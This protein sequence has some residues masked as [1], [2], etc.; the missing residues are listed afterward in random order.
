MWSDVAREKGSHSSNKICPRLVGDTSNPEQIQV[1]LVSGMLS[2]QCLRWLEYLFAPSDIYLYHPHKLV[3]LYFSFNS[4]PKQGAP[5]LLFFFFC[6][7]LTYG[8]V[9]RCGLIAGA[10]LVTYYWVAAYLVKKARQKHAGS[11]QVIVYGPPFL[12]LWKGGQV[13][14][15]LFSML[16]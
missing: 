2:W 11:A 4:F 9:S 16:N 12:S 8:A 13:A 14:Q 7:M 15:L 10:P 6:L 3:C 5:R 1:S